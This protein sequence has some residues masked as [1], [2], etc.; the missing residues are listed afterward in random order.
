[1]LD[2]KN[3][4][5]CYGKVEALRDASFR[6]GVGEIVALLGPNG[7]GKSSALKAVGG[8]LDYYNGSVAGGTVCLNDQDITGSP[9]HRLV[10]Q[11][12][13]MVPEGRRVFPSVQRFPEAGRGRRPY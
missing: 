3:L 1:M 13:A 9:G 2:V 5:V 6:V 4:H 12:V 8:V 7:A 10:Q 11:G